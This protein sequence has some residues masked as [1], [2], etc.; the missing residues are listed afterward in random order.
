MTEFTKDYQPERRGDPKEGGKANADRHLLSNALRLAL[1]REVKDAEG[2]PTRRLNV[3]AEK[4]AQAAEDGDLPSIK[5]T[6]DRTEGKA[7]QAVTLAAPDG[8]PIL[9]W[10]TKP[11]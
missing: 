9:L 4:L 3:I 1:N 11:E 6:F 7:A 10:G 2:K 8:G 5:E